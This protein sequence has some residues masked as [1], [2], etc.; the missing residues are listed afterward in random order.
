MEAHAGLL[1]MAALD[2]PVSGFE[3]DGIYNSFPPR[4]PDQ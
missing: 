1:K 3:R 2:R 4:R